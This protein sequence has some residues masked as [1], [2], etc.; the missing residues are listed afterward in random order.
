M[1]TPL[2]YWHRFAGAPLALLAVLASLA[3][4]PVMA[5]PKPGEGPPPEALAACSQLA[6]NQACSF[7]SPRGP[8]TGTCWAPSGK[9]LACKPQNAPPPPGNGTGRPQQ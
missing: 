7:N 8:V 1:F 3:S 6:A 5:Q 4:T 9:A 2:L